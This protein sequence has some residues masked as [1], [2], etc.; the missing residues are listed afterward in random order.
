MLLVVPSLSGSEEASP[1]DPRSPHRGGFGMNN[2]GGDAVREEDYWLLEKPEGRGAL[3]GLW[4]FLR[5]F[6]YFSE[7]AIVIPSDR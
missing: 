4:R 6:A 1:S 3:N 7:S 2:L 5:C